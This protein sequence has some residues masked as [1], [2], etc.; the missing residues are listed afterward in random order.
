MGLGY[1]FG[2]RPIRTWWWAVYGVKGERSREV[3]WGLG[4]GQLGRYWCA[5]LSWGLP[6]GALRRKMRIFIWAREV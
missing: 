1:V 3:L 2:G 6:E 4:L 5:L